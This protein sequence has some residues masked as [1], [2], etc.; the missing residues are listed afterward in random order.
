VPTSPENGF[1][2]R[3]PCLEEALTPQTKAILLGYPANPTGA[4]M[5]REGLMAIAEFADRNDLWVISDEIHDRLVYGVEQ[6]LRGVARMKE[7]TIPLGGFS[8]TY[9][10]TGF[11]LATCARRP[12]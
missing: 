3:G 6:A 2:P 7:R 4:V 9:A 1:R 5:D 8:K 11:R 10:M 12:Q